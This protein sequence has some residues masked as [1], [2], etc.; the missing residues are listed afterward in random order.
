MAAY[1]LG[2]HEALVLRDFIGANFS[3][4][5]NFCEEFADRGSDGETLADEIFNMLG[6]D[7]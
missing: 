3:Q 1:E 6:G 5:A 4:F 7:V 2:E